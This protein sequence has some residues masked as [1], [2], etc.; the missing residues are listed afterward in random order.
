MAVFVSMSG[1]VTARGRVG[2]TGLRIYCYT[3]KRSIR[4][5]QNDTINKILSFW[6]VS[7][8]DRWLSV[9]RGARGHSAS[10]LR[11]CAHSNL[12]YIVSVRW[13]NCHSQWASNCHS[14]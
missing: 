9:G 4:P 11:A 1:C 3:N 13:H 14:E 5:A 6:L 10:A 7:F 12:E 8:V 2:E